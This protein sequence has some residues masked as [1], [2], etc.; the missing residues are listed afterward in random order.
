VIEVE[1]RDQS[2]LVPSE[3]SGQLQHGCPSCGVLAIT[4]L[5]RTVLN[6]E[7]QANGRGYRP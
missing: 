6:S 5:A 1:P 4:E 3:E 2:R 7:D